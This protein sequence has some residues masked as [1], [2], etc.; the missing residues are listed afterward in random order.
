MPCVRQPPQAQGRM[1]GVITA[2]NVSGMLHIAQRAA[3][4]A[5]KLPRPFKRGS[6]TL[7][8]DG[9]MRVVLTDVDGNKESVTFTRMEVLDCSQVSS[10][11]LA[12]KIG[13]IFDSP[14]RVTTLSDYLKRDEKP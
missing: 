14:T 2:P 13:K 1:M 3:E 6:F 4:I 10:K 5:K 11:E 7:L 12:H 9:S 8:K